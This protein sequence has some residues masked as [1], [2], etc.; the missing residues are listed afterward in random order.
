MVDFLMEIHAKECI[1]LYFSIGPPNIPIT[2]PF[3]LLDNPS[4]LLSYLLNDGIL[5]IGDVYNDFFGLG[6]V[7]Q[8]GDGYIFGS[9]I[10]VDLVGG[11]R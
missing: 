6:F 10:S 1:W 7:T 9:V 2:R 3:I 4:Q 5:C 8:F 11:F